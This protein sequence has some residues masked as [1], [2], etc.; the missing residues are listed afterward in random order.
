MHLSR[1]VRVALAHHQRVKLV[2]KVVVT[3]ANGTRS[4]LR[5]ARSCAEP[6]RQLVDAVDPA[7]ALQDRLAVER[8]ALEC[9]ARN[10]SASESSA[11][12]RFAP[13]Q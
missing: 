3:A 8:D 6:D 1:R 5:R 7:D 9:R 13:T 11:R 2:L 12:A 4:T 10:A